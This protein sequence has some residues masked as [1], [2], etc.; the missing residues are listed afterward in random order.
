MEFDPRMT[1]E[2]KKHV[3]IVHELTK[4]LNISIEEERKMIDLFD[5]ETNKAHQN[6]NIEEKE[7]FIENKTDQYQIPVTAYIPKTISKDASIVVFIHGGGWSMFTRKTYR[8]ALLYMAEN[9]KKIW[10]SIEYRLS[11]E[12]KHPIAITDCCSVVEWVNENK[13][14]LFNSNE[15]VKIGISGDSCGGHLAACVSHKLRHLLSFQL[16][17]YPWLD[18]TCSADSYKEF[19]APIYILQP[20]LL[21]RCMSRYI[22]N[23]EKRKDP[24]VSPLLNDGLVGLPKCLIVNAELEPFIGDSYAY[25]KKLIENGVSSQ[26]YVVKGAIHGFFHSYLDYKNAFFESTNEMLKF[27]NQF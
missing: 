9:S 6:E 11:P 13:S 7:Y 22:D 12:Y 15:N 26:L 3:T 18:L 17:I 20:H 21:E 23:I 24:D 19:T 14:K 16:L 8:P 10:I 27:L 1:E 25:N 5:S 2:T 4:Q